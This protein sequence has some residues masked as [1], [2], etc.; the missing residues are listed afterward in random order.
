MEHRFE[1]FNGGALSG[2]C[3]RRGTEEVQTGSVDMRRNQRGWPQAPVELD[4][5]WQLGS[6]I[7][8]QQALRNWKHTKFVLL[9]QSIYAKKKKKTNKKINKYIAQLCPNLCNPMDCSMPGSSV[10]GFPRQEY[11]SGLPFPSPGDLPDP[12]LNLSLLL[13]R[14]VFFTTWEDPNNYITSVNYYITS[15]HHRNYKIFEQK[16]KENAIYQ[17][18]WN[19]AS[20]SRRHFIAWIPVLKKKKGSKSMHYIS[21]ETF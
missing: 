1:E 4:Q 19:A 18:L 2:G 17:N 7:Q 8:S 14:R 5:D 12:G 20:I 3:Y 9:P 10:H 15:N 16:A 6:K 13:G 11:W 21:Q